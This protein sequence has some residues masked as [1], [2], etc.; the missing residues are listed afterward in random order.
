MIFVLLMNLYMSRVVFQS[1]GVIDY[2]VYNV[3]GSVVV[4]FS[5]INSALSVATT[6]FFSFE[7]HNGVERLN[8]VFNTSIKVQVLLSL[9]VLI[10]AE[11]V[12]LWFVNE[13]LV[14]PEERIYAANWVYQ[15]SII[16]TIVSI[17]RIPYESAITSHEHM[18]AYALFSIVEVLIKLGLVLSMRVVSYD[19]LVYY[20][21]LVAI[22]S[23]VGFVLRF[24]YCKHKYVE[25]K[26]RNV[27][28]K[29]LFKQ[30][31]SFVGWNFFG[32][33][34]GMSVS[35][36]LSFVINLFF[37]P[38]IN[39]ARG[40]AIQVEAAVSQFASSINTAINPQIIKRH[41]IGDNAGMFSLVFFSS[42]ITFILLFILSL[43]IIFNVDYVLNVWLGDIPEYADVFTQLELGY[44]LTLSLTYS[45]NMCAQASGQIKTFQITEGCILLLNIPISIG[46]YRLG[47]PPYSA[48]ISLIIISL[49]AII[50]K[51]QVVQRTIRF[52]VKDYIIYVIVPALVTCFLLFIIYGTMS[53]FI[54]DSFSDLLIKTLIVWIIFIPIVWLVILNNTERGIVVKYVKNLLRRKI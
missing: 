27:F 39:A 24:I 2:G 31:M 18:H 13:K 17:L 47:C 11:T 14:I 3:V 10:L 5:Y 53:N 12:G 28:N 30:M 21:I 37:G 15:L 9:L 44:I 40:I 45:I 43:P 49:T 50:A 8:E 48:F 34:A 35:Q 16:T 32:A 26:L 23:F 46:L 52:P 54:T 25:I 42:K 20:S 1:L 36:G 4:L 22:V 29:D 33:T 41:S 19:K 51:L 38:A 7:M 6:R